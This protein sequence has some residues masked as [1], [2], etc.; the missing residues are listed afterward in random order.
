[1]ILDFR[2][3]P[4]MCGLKDSILFDYDYASRFANMF[5][6]K[7]NES[8]KEK[9][10]S[11]LLQEMAACNITNGVVPF[12]S[13]YGSVEEYI[14]EANKYGNTFYSLLN[15]EPD[16][17]AKSIPS[18]S[19]E[20]IDR[21]VTNGPLTA[22]GMEPSSYAE[23]YCV[24]DHR[25]FSIYEKCENDNISVV[26]TSNIVTPDH[27]SP[28][29]V[30]NILKT[31]PKLRLILIHAWMGWTSQA[32]QQAYMHPNLFI[33][34]DCYLLGAP[35]HRDFID[36]ANTLI[37]GQIIFGSAYPLV[38]LKTAVDYYLNCGFRS[39]V[40]DDVMYYN[41]MRALGLLPEKDFGTLRLNMYGA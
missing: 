18:N 15:I 6:V 2:L 23:P 34:P 26:L 8:V 38:P 9:S 24:D 4:P 3:R 22:V 5:H 12:R 32:C 29:R 13:W 7:P 10:M 25:L 31:F 11:L 17:G 21:L 27:Y 14:N 19:I 37:P 30:A 40:I 33:S 39:E 28:S 35:G 41:G 1:M 16:L 20:E 36:G